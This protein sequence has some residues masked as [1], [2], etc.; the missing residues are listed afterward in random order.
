MSVRLGELLI[1]KGHITVDQ[2]KEAIKYQ[3]DHSCKLG[4]ALVRLG[5]T[6]DQIVASALS[7]QY[8]LPAIDLPNVE[9][10]RQCMNL[11]PM[12]TVI[13]YQ[14]LPVKKVANTLT[15]AVA[16]P[17]D[18]MVLDEIKF[19][20]GYK[21]E[22]VVAPESAIREAIELFYGD[23]HSI[24]LQKVYDEL[25]ADGE[26]YELDLS[27]K[28]KVDIAELERT[29]SEAPI[30]KL[31]NIVLADAIRRGASDI[32][33][34]PYEGELRIRFRIDG[35]LYTMMR[36]PI[37]LRDPI[38]SRLKIMASLDISER[39]LPQDG[40]IRIH[41]SHASK[42][43]R[44]D[45]RVSTLPTLFGEKVVLRL[46]DPEKLPSELE[47]LG[48]EGH[49]LQ[50][51]RSAIER[52]YGMFLVTGPTGSGKTS[53]LYTCLQLLNTDQVNIMTAE[54][55]VEFNFAGINQVPINENIGRTFASILRAFLRQD[56]NIIMVG[57]VRDLETAEIAVKA[58]LTG[59]LVLSTLHTND[60]PSTITR[61]LNMGVEPF[62]VA[63][64]V[65]LICAQRLVRVICTGCRKQ[66]ETPT[67]AL[68]GL[69]L[70]ESE[71][72]KVKT[73][74]GAG[75]PACNHSG[76]KGRTGLF[77]V[78][79]ITPAI[80][81]LILSETSPTE[82]RRTARREGMLT[83]REVGLLKIAK[84]I[85]TVDEVARETALI[86]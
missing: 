27:E 17:T 50:Q 75:C 34:E 60:A 6:N 18:V 85:T 44:L 81:D 10:D 69:G 84:G 77:E 16:D 47:K 9:I 19:M 66:I 65:N 38:V 5:L 64:S 32:H 62:L 13:R 71:A 54:D 83:L 70:P 28:Q 21:V 49:S 86:S 8:G 82:I 11:I 67:E 3:H 31:V 23:R 1:K 72:R 41:I 24:E 57:E 76:Y 29:S 26:E 4:S 15:V 52:P 79:E 12:E 7:Q 56:P 48:F 39:R 61:L 42:K 37:R 68:V 73:Y 36:P 33:L 22:P 20:T 46:L 14:V 40:R 45:F 78:M 59:H 51:V 63:S 25:V 58:A 55:P 74:H 53:T 35:V 2:L 80:Q 30:I 43:K